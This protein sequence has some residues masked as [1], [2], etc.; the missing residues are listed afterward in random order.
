[1]KK[2]LSIL[3]AS[4]LI[5][6]MTGCNAPSENTN[7]ES[8]S[9]SVEVSGSSVPD[10]SD[11]QASVS[12]TSST[13]STSSSEVLVSSDAASSMPQVE[14]WTDFTGPDGQPVTLAGAA[15]D[16]QGRVTFDYGFI[17]YAP[18][19][20]YDSLKDPDLINWETFEFAPY[21]GAYTP[22]IKRLKA[23]DV[24]ENGLKVTKASHTLMYETF[25]DEATLELR[26]EWKTYSG[27][28]AFDGELTLSGAMYCV[29]EDDYMVFGGELYFFPDTTNFSQLPVGCD[30]TSPENEEYTAFELVYPDAKLA[31]VGGALYYSG[32]ISDIENTGVIE[33]GKAA[34]V[35]VTINNIRITSSNTDY[36]GRGG[37][38]FAD[39]VSIEKIDL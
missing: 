7:T 22:T 29:P 24:L 28:L 6:G 9:D 33:K 1:M 2:F 20:Y 5:L 25:I 32:N 23:G 21:N 31:V 17:K 19:I 18:S 11:A 27:E 10:D 34:K 35:N 30:F 15:V 16:E 39:I 13:S 8:G 4:T 37:G 38:C 14:N 3:C 12:N 26:S 36:G